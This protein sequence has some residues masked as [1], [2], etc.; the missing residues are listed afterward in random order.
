MPSLEG[1][2][3]SSGEQWTGD[4]LQ[5]AELGSNQGKLLTPGVVG[6]FPDGISEQVN[7]NAF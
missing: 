1:E 2:T 7:A 4:P 5:G 3:K 6:H